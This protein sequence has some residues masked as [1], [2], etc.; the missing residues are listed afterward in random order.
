MKCIQNQ[1]ETSEKKML[2]W[3]F[4]VT[5]RV[6]TDSRCGIDRVK[7][8]RYF[9]IMSAIWILGVFS[10]QD[11]HSYRHTPDEHALGHLSTFVFE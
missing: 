2:V 6:M 3:L 7:P 5:E 11:A 10:H 9:L 1:L 8:G 4:K